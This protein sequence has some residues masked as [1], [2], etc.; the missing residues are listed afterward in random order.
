MVDTIEEDNSKKLLDVKNEFS[1]HEIMDQV[2]FVYKC[3]QV[4]NLTDG[5]CELSADKDGNVNRN[6]R[7]SIW[8]EA[9]NLLNINIAQSESNYYEIDEN[10]W[11][12]Y[13]SVT[14]KVN[15]SLP[16]VYEV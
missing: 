11:K 12:V 8:K 6:S 15:L 16:H 9:Y 2:K 3:Y 10:W 13:L 5:F 14:S 1:Q 4:E 7:P